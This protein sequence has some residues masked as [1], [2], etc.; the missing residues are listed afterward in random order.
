MWSRVSRRARVAGEIEPAEEG[1]GAVDDDELLMV[2]AAGF[3]CGSTGN[4]L[5]ESDL[6]VKVRGL[7][8]PLTR[9]RRR[10]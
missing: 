5:V 1:N 10:R 8:Q 9:A 7:L 6:E 2:T 3:G 4:P